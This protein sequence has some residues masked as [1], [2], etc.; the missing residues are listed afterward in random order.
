M[1]IFGGDWLQKNW[2]GRKGGFPKVPDPKKKKPMEITPAD[3][4]SIIYTF[5]VHIYIYIYIYMKK[6]FET[7]KTWMSFLH[8]I[9]EWQPGDLKILDLLASLLAQRSKLY[10]RLEATW[11]SVILS[12]SWVGSWICKFWRAEEAFVVVNCFRA[13]K[14]GKVRW[15][16]DWLS[17]LSHVHQIGKSPAESRGTQHHAV[18]KDESS[19]VLPSRNLTVRPA[20]KL[21]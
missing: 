3:I 2:G 18:V 19:V 17:P 7:V 14:A 21:L 20:E 12:L 6:L 9:T 11:K 10:W 5:S 13:W 16:L 15:G 4:W 8:F 1:P